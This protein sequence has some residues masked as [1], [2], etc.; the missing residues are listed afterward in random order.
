[1]MFCSGCGSRLLTA[2]KF[3]HSCG[4]TTGVKDDD[5]LCVAELEMAS[6]ERKRHQSTP[7]TFDE[8]REKKGKERSSR[9]VSS[10]SVKKG[11]KE[12]NESEVTIHIGLI[13]LKEEELKVIRG[14]TLPLKVLPSIGAEELLRKGADKIVRFNS[15]LSLYGA[16]SFALLYPDRTEVKCL[17]GGTEPF[18]LQRY[19]EELG[20]SYN[21]ITLYLCKK[22]AILDALFLK[23]YNSDE[24]DADL[25]AYEE[26]LKMTQETESGG[27]TGRP[28]VN[29]VVTGNLTTNTST[30]H[31]AVTYTATRNTF[32][33]CTVQTAASN[34]STAQTATS[35]TST[36]QTAT[37]N[38]S[39]VQT[40][41]SNI[42]T[43]ETAA[44]SDTLTQ[45]I[46][47][48]V[49]GAEVLNVEALLTDC[50]VHKI[51]LYRA[52]LKDNLI[53]V[54]K[55]PE[56]LQVNLDVTLI[57]DNGKEEEGKGAGVFRDT[58]SSF[59]S[60]FF[61][62]LTVGTQEKVPAIRHDYQ[63]AEW[64]AI[65][66]ILIYGYIKERY[67]PLPLSRAFVALCLFG[68]E[69]MT[70]D[71]LLSSFKLYIS[72]DE[73]ETLQKCLEEKIEDEYDDVLDF[74]SNYKCYRS[75]TQENIL[76][77]V[78]EL[79]H[80]EIIQKPRYV[81]NCWA[82]I[83]KPMISLPDFQSVVTLENL[84]DIKRPTAKKILKLIKSEPATDQER[85]C[86]DH[87][88]K[89][90]R[91]LQGKSLSLF[92]QFITGSDIIS[93]DTIEVAFSALDGASRR[94]VAHTCGPL[95]EIPSSYQS[96]NELSEEFSELM[97]HKEAWHF[98][99]V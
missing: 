25:P 24:S 2:A 97:Q 46:Q 5:S 92:L 68:E 51:I 36:V 50:P 30:F 32:T 1:M 48:V 80:Q 71:F 35:N 40:A 18:T 16:T 22:T 47:S 17:P 77:I 19:K 79:A 83:L 74:L 96:Y 60:Q 84:Y 67:F 6:S 89:Y 13:R 90:I 14:S 49:T 88:K 55:D 62:S 73:R 28:W 82:P 94:P 4:L 31:P 91:S 34:I 76:Q 87:L 75:P 72:E 70:S 44:N 27:D 85:Q 66:R 86:L 33:D 8:Y 43:A 81:M 57:G 7:L 15:D 64:E 3:C 61:N 58:L 29:H 63:R 20:K 10:K 12:N 56:I 93:C 59:W 21:R 42:S 52:F 37:S 69:S 45:G 23:S 53:E 98:N 99:I 41:T 9:F 11:K 54:F 38:I 65:A 78:S 95:L 26:L 39:T